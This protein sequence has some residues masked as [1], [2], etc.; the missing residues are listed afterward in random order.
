MIFSEININDE[1]RIKNDKVRKKYENY[2]GKFMPYLDL[3]E[4]KV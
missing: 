2:I 4:P 3:P 1:W